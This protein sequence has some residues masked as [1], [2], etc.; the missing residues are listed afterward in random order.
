MWPLAQDVLSDAWKVSV[1]LVTTEVLSC[2]VIMMCCCNHGPLV[3][4]WRWDV[5]RSA[6]V[7]SMQC[8]WDEKLYVLFLKKG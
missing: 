2:G 6:A 5:D 7:C 3:L 1:C 8:E 4:C